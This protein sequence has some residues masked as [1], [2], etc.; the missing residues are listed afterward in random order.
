MQKKPSHSH[1]KELES[2]DEPLPENQPPETVPERAVGG[3]PGLCGGQNIRLSGS[4]EKRGELG[5]GE[6]VRAMERKAVRSPS[7]AAER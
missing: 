5:E 1:E 3:A 6:R 4:V 2:L 7:S